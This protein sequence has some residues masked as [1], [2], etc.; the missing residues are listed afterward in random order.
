MDTSASKLASG[1]GKP[2]APSYLFFSPPPPPPLPQGPVLQPFSSAL[3]FYPITPLIPPPPRLLPQGPVLQPYIDA[4]LLTYTRLRD[5]IPNFQAFLKRP[6]VKRL[7]QT[8][9][10]MQQVG[11]GEG[12]R[13]EARERGRRGGK[14]DRRERGK[15]NRLMGGHRFLSPHPFVLTLPPSLSSLTPPSPSL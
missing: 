15:E 7:Q 11:E 10:H 9:V 6:F 5:I 4:N 1:K 12:R 2:H 13:E 14:D 8:F 3:P